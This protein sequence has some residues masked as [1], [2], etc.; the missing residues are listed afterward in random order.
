MAAWSNGSEV[1]VASVDSVLRAFFGARFVL[2][3]STTTEI[4]LDI[5]FVI[6]LLSAPFTRSAAPLH[7]ECIDEGLNR[8]EV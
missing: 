4:F 2:E 6:T 8:K 5:G 7:L 1:R 3:R